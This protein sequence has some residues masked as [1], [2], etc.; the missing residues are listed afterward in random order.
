MAAWMKRWRKKHPD[1]KRINERKYRQS[2]KGKLARRKL[3]DR[4][5]EQISDGYV[6]DRLTGHTNVPRGDWPDWLVQ[7]KRATIK[8]KRKYGIHQNHRRRV[9][10]AN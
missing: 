1:R 10:E 6:R 9:I 4:I 7:L 8:L 5:T 3:G 2:E